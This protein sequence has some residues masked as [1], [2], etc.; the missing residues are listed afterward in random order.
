MLLDASSEN[1]GPLCVLA[2][3]LS[4]LVGGRALAFSRQHLC[5]LVLSL[6]VH[7]LSNRHS[8]LCLFGDS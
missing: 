6:E 1:P 8:N 7:V 3:E 5:L 4:V 2:S